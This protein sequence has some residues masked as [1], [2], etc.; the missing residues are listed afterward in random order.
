MLMPDYERILRLAPDIVL[1]SFEGN[2]PALEA[3]LARANIPLYVA[4]VDSL[5]ALYTTLTNLSLLFS[6]TEGQREGMAWERELGENL[7]ALRGALRGQ[8]IFFQIGDTTQAWSFGKT[9]LLHDLIRLAGAENLGARRAGSFP[10]FDSEA[11][12]RLDPDMV[13]LLSGSDPKSDA[14]FWARYAPRA[15]LL[16]VP[17]DRFERPGPRMVEAMR[18]IMP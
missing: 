17:P 18:G 7:N 13:I 14:A 12:S 2:P 15:R 8:R 5:A 16:R 10:Q 4:R 3:V 11:L 1:A 6:L 9:T